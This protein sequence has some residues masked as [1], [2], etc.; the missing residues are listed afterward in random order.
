M[1]AEV[2]REEQWFPQFV[3]ALLGGAAVA[4]AVSVAA[5]RS[6]A[7]LWVRRLLAGAGGLLALGGAFTPMRTTV[8]R[9]GVTVTFGLPGWIRFHIA[10][11]EIRGVEAVTYR[12]LAE[13]GG[14]GIRFGAGGT[15]AY[16]ARGNR[17]V[18]IRTDRRAFLIGS[19][20]PDELADAL[21]QVGS[22]GGGK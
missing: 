17:G 22:L 19:Q 10:A 2:Y 21:C 11:D 14:W 6:L 12:P 13:F 9:E 8:T 5:A 20:R 15:R 7:P 16:T 1:S 4:A 3:G 18:R